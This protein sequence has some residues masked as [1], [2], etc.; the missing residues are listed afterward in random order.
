MCNCTYCAFSVTR[1]ITAC[2]LVGFFLSVSINFLKLCW[3][4]FWISSVRVSPATN[5]TL[6]SVSTTWP[7]RLCNNKKIVRN[8]F[9]KMKVDIVTYS[10]SMHRLDNRG[11]N[12]DASNVATLQ[13]SSVRNGE[14]GTSNLKR[15]ISVVAVVIQLD[16]VEGGCVLLDVPV[17]D[18][19]FSARGVT[20]HFQLN[21]PRN[22]V[23]S[24]KN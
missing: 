10:K 18:V 1:R 7:E 3:L 24:Y 22:I 9:P 11:Q 16:R 2:L 4:G 8:C 19:F 6:S 12:N 23:A 15:Q 20:D 13:N 5:S 17:G 21:R 14:W